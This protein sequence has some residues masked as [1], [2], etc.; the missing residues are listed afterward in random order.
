M[1][2]AKMLKM[3][4]ISIN[5]EQD[6]ILNA[7][8]K[9]AWVQLDKEQPSFEGLKKIQCDKSE[10][11]D[12]RERV[13]N[14]LSI[15]TRYAKE[16]MKTLP[17][18]DGFSVDY[19]SF[20]AIKGEEQKWLDVCDEVKQFNDDIY[21]LKAEILAKESELEGFKPYLG[22]SERF[23]QFTN[24][25]KTV[26]KLGYSE[27]NKFAK[28]LEVVKDTP[29]IQ[30]TQLYE[31]DKGITYCA[32]YHESV[33]HEAERILS[34]HAFIK[35]LQNG[36]FTASEKIEELRVDIKQKQREIQTLQDNI[37]Q[38]T[39]ELMGLKILSDYYLFELE[40]LS[41]QDGFLQ[42][43]RTFL[44]EAFIPE[45]RK[46]EIESVLKDFS[47]NIYIEFEPLGKEDYAPTLMKNKKLTGSFE[48]VTNLYSA[49]K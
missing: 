9:T 16:V 49:P 6:A 15:I 23:S 24:T 31:F 40:K 41:G 35:C 4:L 48:F 45:E 37:V 46:Q 29:L 36:D 17:Y 33:Q 26:C 1:A 32:I 12:K 34:E 38:K 7:L 11:K 25:K 43:E 44:L 5:G 28:L 3:R 27:K 13:E 19:S 2:I 42:S 10:V 30:I 39:S 20:I 22:V 8:H 18:A 47:G 14:T 21:R